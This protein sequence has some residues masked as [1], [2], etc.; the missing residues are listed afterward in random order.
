[1]FHISNSFVQNPLF[2]RTSAASVICMIDPNER[3]FSRADALV[4]H[5]RT[6]T[7]QPQHQPKHSPS[8]TTSN[9]RLDTRNPLDLREY[10]ESSDRNNAT[11]PLSPRHRQEDHQGA[12]EPPIEQERRHTRTPAYTPTYVLPSLMQTCTA[13]LSQLRAIHARVRTKHHDQRMKDEA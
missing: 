2:H 9:L 3:L 1:V 13:D 8:H 10:N 5:R 11:N 12:F 6:S 7:R 4:A